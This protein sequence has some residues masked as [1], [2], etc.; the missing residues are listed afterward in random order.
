MNLI[1][2][3]TGRKGNHTNRN[4]VMATQDNFLS[5]IK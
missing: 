1:R 4:A 2:D 3:S 5:N